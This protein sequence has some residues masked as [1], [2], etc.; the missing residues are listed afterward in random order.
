MFFFFKCN[1]SQDDDDDNDDFNFEMELA[2][3][4]GLDGGDVP[5]GEGPENQHTNIKWVSIVHLATVQ[6]V[7][8]LIVFLTELTPTDIGANI[9]MKKQTATKRK[10]FFQ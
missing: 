6:V 9:T 3:M 4:E 1:F 7:V 10:I 5:V 8:C 2:Q